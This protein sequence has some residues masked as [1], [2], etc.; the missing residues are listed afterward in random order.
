[1]V[2]VLISGGI[3]TTRDDDETITQ[4]ITRHEKAVNEVNN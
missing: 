3:I 1:M 2:T 4:H